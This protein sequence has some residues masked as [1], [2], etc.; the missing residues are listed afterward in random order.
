MN[1]MIINISCIIGIVLVVILK[2]FEFIEKHILNKEYSK[3]VTSDAFSQEIEVNSI[4]VS[5]LSLS[6]EKTNSKRNF[7]QIRNC[8]KINA[9]TLKPFMIYDHP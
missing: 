2:G 3:V 8:R 1:Y 5:N 6:K 4:E 9:Q 7:L